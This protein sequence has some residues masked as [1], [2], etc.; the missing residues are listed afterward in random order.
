MFQFCY[1]I[2]LHLFIIL[3]GHIKS[4][5]LLI[6]LAMVIQ[7]TRRKLD[8][9]EGGTLTNMGS[10][11]VPVSPHISKPS[12]CHLPA[13]S[14]QRTLFVDTQYPASFILFF[15]CST[16]ILLYSPQYFS[17][18]HICLSSPCFQ[19]K[20]GFSFVRDRPMPTPHG[21]KTYK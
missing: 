10:A 15:Q 4:W 3:P 5:N 12:T 9:S 19:R 2:P 1:C 13:H 18:P 14:Q 16:S 6:N 17:F 21:N 8:R 7:S 20:T 11:S